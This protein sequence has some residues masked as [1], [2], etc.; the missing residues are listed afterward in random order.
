MALIK[1]IAA[2]AA[3]SALAFST[4]VA[5]GAGENAPQQKQNASAQTESVPTLRVGSLTVYAPFEYMDS[6]TGQYEGFDMDLVR[7]LG[8]REGY[9]I[10]IVSMTLDGLIPA[11]MADNIDVAVSAL[12]ITPERSEKVDF[13]KPY[14]NAGL[15]V[16]TTRDNAPKIKSLKDLEGKCLCAEIG[17]SGALFMKR[18]P[19]TTIR[20]FNSAAD[21]FLE[22]NKN[23]CYAML[24]DGPVNKYFLRQDAAKSMNLVA[25]DWVVSDDQYGFAV[26]KGNAE[27]LKKLDDALDAMK[28]DGTYDRIYDKWFGDTGE[29]IKAN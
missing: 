23:G 2:A 19:G 3:V 20:T 16:M 18:I 9:K 22:L 15:T 5:F 12:T 27:L 8:K 17:S 25:L 21:A 14:I 28:K 13:T 11:L 6:A 4:F 24:N 10:E 26:K 1:K 29:N 7:E